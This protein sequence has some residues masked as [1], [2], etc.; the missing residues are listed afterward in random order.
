[1]MFYNL[2]WKCTVVRFAASR[3][4]SLLDEEEQEMVGLPLD[5]V[6]LTP[7]RCAGNIRY[8]SY[9][10][11]PFSKTRQF[12]EYCSYRDTH[13]QFNKRSKPPLSRFLSSNVAG[14]LVWNMDIEHR[15]RRNGAFQCDILSVRGV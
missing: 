8:A 1:M 12:N 11:T 5:C 14:S 10:V 6:C 2:S 9:K 4:V 7:S 3:M 15:W 13:P